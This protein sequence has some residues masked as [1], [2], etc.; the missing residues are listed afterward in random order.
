MHAEVKK[1]IETEKKKCFLSGRRE[2]KTIMTGSKEK[3]KI[4]SPA[5][6]IAKKISRPG[7]KRK[8]TY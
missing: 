6:P 1:K 3:E 7:W 2:E 4:G 5:S 8:G